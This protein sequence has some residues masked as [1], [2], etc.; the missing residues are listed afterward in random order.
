MEQWSSGAVEQWSSGA[1]EQWSSGAV[2][3]EGNT[4]KNGCQH[5]INKFCE[6]SLMTLIPKLETL[7]FADEEK[8]PH[9]G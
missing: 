2:E 8:C 5:K 7:N 6:Q 9:I 3:Q 4:C 1:V